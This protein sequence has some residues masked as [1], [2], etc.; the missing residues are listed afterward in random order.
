MRSWAEERT[1]LSEG[2]REH[3][4]QCIVCR[5]CESVCPSGI[6]MGD[7]MEAFRE[8]MNR[9]RPTGVAASRLGRFLLRRVLPDRGRIALLSDALGLYEKSGLPHLAQ[10]ILNGTAPGLARAHGMRPPV[11]PRR[12]RRIPTHRDGAEA[13][14]AHGEKRARVGLFLGCIA[15]EW[16]APMHRATI[17]V[18][19]AN[20]CDVVIP[21]AQTCCGAL[22]RHAGMVED[23][24]GLLARNAAAFGEAGVDAVVV[25]AAGCGASLR[26]P[27]DGNPAEPPVRDIC[28]F[29]S[30]LGL[31][32][33]TGT[34]PHRVAYDQPCHLVHGQ[35][36]GRE[37]VEGLLRQIPDLELVPLARSERC[38][39][40]GGIY[41]LLQGEIADAVQAE[42]VAD[43][44]ASGAEIVA[45]GNPGCALQIASGLQGRAIQV[46]HPV[47]LLDRA[48]GGPR[49]TPQAL[50]DGSSGTCITKCCVGANT[51]ISGSC[52]LD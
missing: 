26:E 44:L 36:I 37:T 22:H 14:P 28:E 3:L 32:P 47:E 49:E 46:V 39:G 50:R 13:L 34:V 27:L 21:R 7:M 6:H 8:K 16:F 5:A 30:E 10:A 33:P 15:S 31:R 4:D 52:Q 29:L 11:P 12:E 24:R 41:N 35:K 19:Q 17:R 20:G 9:T 42:K 1:E 18:L 38:C 40:A 23:A 45:T 48:Y 25:N 2:A 43:L 51:C